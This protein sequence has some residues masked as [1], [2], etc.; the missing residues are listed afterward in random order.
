MLCLLI[1][2]VL[3]DAGIW[4]ITSAERP[5]NQYDASI[6]SF[7]ADHDGMDDGSGT[8]TDA[9][10][11]ALPGAGCNLQDIAEY[12]DEYACETPDRNIDFRRG[13]NLKVFFKNHSLSLTIDPM[14][15][16]AW[17]E[18]TLSSLK[19][20]SALSQTAGTR[21]EFLMSSITT[22]PSGQPRNR[23]SGKSDMISSDIIAFQANDQT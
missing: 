17:Q 11:F 21:T 14:D 2:A 9:A 8:C 12:P 19:T 3:I 16:D 20:A 4:N 10:G 13:R 6:P 15:L 1:P 18:E 7:H 23:T 22:V 5:A